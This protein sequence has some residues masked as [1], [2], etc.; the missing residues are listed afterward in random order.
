MSQRNFSL[1]GIVLRSREI[2]SGGRVVSLLTAEDGVIDAFMFGGSKSKLR[3]L[4]SPWH[5]G[6]A[7][8]YRDVQKDFT[9][10]SDFDARLEFP[11]IRTN[12]EALCVAAFMSEFISETSALGGEGATAFA[13]VHDTLLALET[14]LCSRTAA[15]PTSAHLPVLLQFCLRALSLMGML[16]ETASCCLC[17]GIIV[18]NTVHSYARLHTG[19]VCAGCRID[20]E[21]GASFIDVPSGAVVW[22]EK[23]LALPFA[24]AAR[25]GLAAEA[26]LALEACTL[27]IV[28]QVVDSPLKTLRQLE[29]LR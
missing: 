14:M 22:L 8:L 29:K 13:L 9:R 23:T 17:A 2:P 12:L 20:R 11:T 24:Q 7:W 18:A 5:E 26:L 21:E 15:A 27:D 25:I 16:P 1:D 10:L 3:S 28:R 6:R 4:A 19:F